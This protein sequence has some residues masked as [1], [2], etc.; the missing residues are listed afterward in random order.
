[1]S[2]LAISICQVFFFFLMKNCFVTSLA[3]SCIVSP[4]CKKCHLTSN[5]TDSHLNMRDILKISLKESLTPTFV[6]CAFVKHS[7]L[8]HPV[9]HPVNYSVPHTPALRSV[10][11][12]A[13][14]HTVG[15]WQA[16]CCCP[17]VVTVA[18][19]NAKRI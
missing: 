10:I 3:G 9:C 1:M 14:H 6:V 2:K 4:C 13:A 11:H 16:G 18:S 19:R 17:S 7:D 15:V 12:P 8:C 5:E